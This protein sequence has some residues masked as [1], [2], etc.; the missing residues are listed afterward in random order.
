MILLTLLIACP[1]ITD[2][3]TVEQETGLEC[4]SYDFCCET[5]CE[6]VGETTHYGEPDPCDCEEDF[7]SDSRECEPVDGVCEF[8]D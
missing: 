4:V 3:A 6:A 7:F 1:G 5:L 8:V 2:T